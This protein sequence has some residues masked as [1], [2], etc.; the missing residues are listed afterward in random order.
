M[1][2]KVTALSADVLAGLGGG[3]SKGVG[4]LNT[5]SNGAPGQTGVDHALATE[6]N[7]GS[8]NANPPAVAPKAGDGSLSTEYGSFANTVNGNE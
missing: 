3:G 5:G 1:A 4:S 2:P 7:V 6:T 8:V